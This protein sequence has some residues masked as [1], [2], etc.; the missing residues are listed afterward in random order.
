MMGNEQRFEIE[1]KYLIKALPEGL[2]N[3]KH[4]E[5]EQ[6]Y[7]ST[8]PVVRIRKKI[9]HAAK[10][11]MTGAAANESYVLTIKSSGMLSRQEYEMDITAEEYRNLTR[12]VEGNIITKTRYFMPLNDSDTSKLILELDIF[13]D[14]FSGLVMGEIEFPD[15][16]TA[17]S[18]ETAGMVSD[19]LS[20]I[21]SKEVTY[22]K[23]FHNSTMSSMS[24]AEIRD[25][26]SSLED[27]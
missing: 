12:K 8:V 16:K 10:A 6:G 9:T 15:K 23:R 13:E 21:L 11:D 4:T 25:F 1:R 20:K 7:I 27:L 18:F 2:G 5:I 22:D 24:E 17:D 19:I 14:A 3:Y 26:I